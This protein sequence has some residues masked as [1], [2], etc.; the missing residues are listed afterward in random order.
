VEC[1]GTDYLV[2]MEG[3]M[4]IIYCTPLVGLS[5]AMVGCSA[6]ATLASM[7][8]DDIEAEVVSISDG[9][10]IK[11]MNDRQVSRSETEIVCNGLGI[12]SD[13]SE[14][15]T[16]YRAYVDAEGELMVAFDTDDAAQAAYRSAVQQAEQEVQA[17]QAEFEAEME[18]HLKVYEAE[19][20]G[21]GF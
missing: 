16:R 9:Q 5:L 19:A 18:S 15:Q 11:I 8:C 2:N 13:N 20:A 6:S 12:Y 21:A 17:A 3:N 14:V 10:L 4:K 1:R 7:S